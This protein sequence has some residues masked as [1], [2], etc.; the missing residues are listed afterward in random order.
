MSFK[1]KTVLAIACVEF[2]A[3]LI[4]ISSTLNIMSDTTEDQVARYTAT[5]SNMLAA[6]VRDA[7]IAFD[8]AT[9]QTYADELASNTDVLHAS[10]LDSAGSTLVISGKRR[11]SKP[12]A[13]FRRVT[14]VVEESGHT[15]G[16]IAMD[17][18]V[19][20]INEGLKSAQ[21]QALIIAT[22]ELLAVA[23]VSILLGGYL[24]R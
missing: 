4:L 10:V 14:R 20:G 18:D 23:L 9:L 8:I 5:V 2:L 22:I 24:T 7:L 13:H 16:S 19:S 21:H 15:F 11:E 12:G 6:T 1:L 3:L 17:I